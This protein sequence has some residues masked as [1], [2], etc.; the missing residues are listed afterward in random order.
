MFTL[1]EYIIYFTEITKISINY[2][3]TISIMK[4]ENI[5]KNLGLNF[6]LWTQ[7]GLWFLF[8]FGGVLFGVF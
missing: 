2:Q 7:F 5:Q 1:K 6:S 3:W 8:S 4:T